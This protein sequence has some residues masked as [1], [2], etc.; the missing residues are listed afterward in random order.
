MGPAT[1]VLPSRILILCAQVAAIGPGIGK[2]ALQA[3]AEHAGPRRMFNVAAIM[4]STEKGVK[5]VVIIIVVDYFGRMF[6]AGAGPSGWLPL[7]VL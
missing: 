2:L 1:E 5:Q 4:L 6:G 7:P 3:P